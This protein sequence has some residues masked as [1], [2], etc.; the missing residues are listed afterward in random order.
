MA[1]VLVLAT[2]NHFQH[3]L[4]VTASNSHFFHVRQFWQWV[5][6]NT[7]RDISGI[8]LIGDTKEK[9][10]TFLFFI[11]PLTSRTYTNLM[12]FK[13]A[14][15]CARLYIYHPLFFSTPF[16]P[17]SRALLHPF[18]TRFSEKSP[19]FRPSFRAQESRSQ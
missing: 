14:D 19:Q 17:T 13:R 16:P 7:K 10:G 11:V 2:P 18:F 1:R 4:W 5:S 15:S 6:I 8:H 9:G 12:H 3:Y